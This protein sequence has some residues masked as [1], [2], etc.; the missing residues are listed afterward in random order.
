MDISVCILTYNEEENIGK[1]LESAL[2]QR[3]FDGAWE[4]LVIDGNSTDNT[5]NIVKA[6][7]QRTDRIRLI[8]NGKKKIAPGRNIAI[9]ES[10]YP[11]IAFT[12]ADCVVPE[13]WLQRLSSVYDELVKKDENV[14]GVGGGNIPPA[15]SSK[16]TQALGLYL[17]SFLGSFN[18]PQGRN[19]PEIRKVTS[20]ACL[21]VL[22]YKEVLQE[23][24]GFDETLG[25][26]SE[27]QDINLRLD[28]KGYSLYF[29]PNVSV[30][31]KFRPDITGWL[32]NMALYGRGRAIISLKHTLFLTPFFILPMC[33]IISMFMVPLGC[34]HYVFFL[35]L[36]YFPIIGVYVFVIAF[37]EK[38]IL[39]F[40]K[41]LVIF[42]STHFVYAFNLFTE[43]LKICTLKLFKNYFNRNKVL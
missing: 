29:I 38:K 4:L 36:V 25:N 35:P 14:A 17:N 34:I 27:D 39:Y 15:V 18:S 31:H 19:F 28:K 7:Q 22:Y 1:C 16:F 32:K 40:R 21:N 9:Q 3:G 20:L 33:F 24:G 5:V 10:R 43:S 13:E 6:F 12:D 30:F 37:S 23:I 8:A 42:I 2:N 11:F 26:I 41:A